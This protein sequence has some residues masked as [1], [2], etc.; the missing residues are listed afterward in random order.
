MGLIAENEAIDREHRR[1]I[2][3]HNALDF[4]GPR[5]RQ[6][7]EPDLGMSIPA[8]PAPRVAAMPV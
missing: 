6:R 2:L 4:Y 5:L 8:S 1:R 3:S 7:M